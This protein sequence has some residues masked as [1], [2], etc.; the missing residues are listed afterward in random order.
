MIEEVAPIRR[1]KNF[2]YGYVRYQI[3]QVRRQLDEGKTYYEIAQG[4]GCCEATIKYN[5]KKYLPEYYG[6][7][8][9]GGGGGKKAGE[10]KGHG[11]YPVV[12]R[13]DQWKDILDCRR[14]GM[15]Y[16]E[17]ARIYG[18]SRER[19]RQI[20]R[21]LEPGLVGYYVTNIRHPPKPCE[22][23]GGEVFRKNVSSVG[24]R[25]GLNLCV[26]C[27][28]VFSPYRR[29]R[30]TE[31]TYRDRYLKVHEGR[32]AGKTWDKVG[33]EIAPHLKLALESNWSVFAHRVYGVY[34]DAVERVKAFEERQGWLQ[35]VYDGMPK[36]Q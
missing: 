29:A 24:T 16:E 21:G 15:I 4:F 27:G 19:I 23:C 17:I 36:G 8:Q 10:W 30:I 14:K 13:R 3:E 6:R 33:K 35:R 26:G 25:W 2:L 5:V 28:Q 20:I 11:N 34:I 9:R 22:G 18:V 12:I 31:A 1:R 7:R 32:L